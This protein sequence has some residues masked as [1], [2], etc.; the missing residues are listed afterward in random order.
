M[1]K[2]AGLIVLCITCFC[3]GAA[4]QEPACVEPRA[5]CAFFDQYLAAFNARDWEA[6]RATFD[7]SITVMFDRPAPPQRVDGRQAVEA[8]FRRVFPPP[9]A[10]PSQLPPPVV[11]VHL[12]AQDYGDVVVVSFEIAGGNDVSRRTVI[13][14]RGSSGWKVVHIH[15]S[16][17][18]A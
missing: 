12:R 1:R 9:G 3:T 16:S 4:A 18:P 7:D 10:P 15:G 11:P 14:H 6:F 5:A 17:G 13:L 2:V 8:M